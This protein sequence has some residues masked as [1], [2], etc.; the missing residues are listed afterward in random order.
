MWKRAGALEWMVKYDEEAFKAAWDDLAPN[1]TDGEDDYIPCVSCF[2]NRGEIGNTAV[3]GS[4]FFSDVWPHGG[5]GECKNKKGSLPRKRQRKRKI[6]EG[7]NLW[8]RG[9]AYL[10]YRI[11]YTS[12]LYIY[13]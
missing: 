1:F 8:D 11:I 9:S 2:S 13:I 10:V 3:F 4:T 6:N 12:S 5:N 7:P